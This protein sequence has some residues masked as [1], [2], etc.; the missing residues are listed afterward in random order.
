VYLEPRQG[1]NIEI[2]YAGDEATPDVQSTVIG[3]PHGIHRFQMGYLLGKGEL[4]TKVAA[5]FFAFRHNPGPQL[6]LVC[7]KAKG[8]H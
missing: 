1:F 6:D 2:L 8:V 3:M 4:P 7:N 5:Q